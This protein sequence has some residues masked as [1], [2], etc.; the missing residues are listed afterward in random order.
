MTV[1]ILSL[2]ALCFAA[3][4][5]ACQSSAP[6]SPINESHAPPFERVENQINP[7]NSRDFLSQQS[8]QSTEQENRISQG[9]GVYFSRPIDEE[10]NLTEP[11]PD[12]Q[13]GQDFVFNSAPIALIIDEVLSSYKVNYSVSPNVHGN[14]S[15]RLHGVSSA[16]EAVAGLN[17]ALGL[18]SYEITNAPGGYLISSKGDASATDSEIRFLSPD[19]A[20]LDGAETAVLQLRYSKV[21]DVLGIARPLLPGNLLKGSDEARGFVLLQ[22]DATSLRRAIRLLRSLDV[23]WLESVSTGVFPIQNLPAEDLVAEITPIINRMG[24]ISLVPIERLQTVVVFART[25]EALGITETWIERLDIKGRLNAEENVLVY[26]ARHADAQALVELASPSFSRVRSSNDGGNIGQSENQRPSQFNNS[27]NAPSYENIFISVDEGRNSIVAQGESSELIRLQNLLEMLDQPQRQVI[28]EATIAEVQLTGEN[29]FG[30]QWRLIEDRLSAAFSPTSSGAPSSLFPG[31][32]ISYTN[33]G[34]DAVVNALASTS[35]VEIV[36]APRL[37]VLNNEPA[38]LQIGDQVPVI[39]QSAVS[40]TDPGAPVVNSTSYRD[41]GVILTVTPQIR[42]GG[43]IVLEVSQEVSNVAQTTT[44][45]IDSPTITQRS[46]ESKLVV[47][48]GAT[49][50]LGG[51]L[52]TTSSQSRLGLPYL[53]DVPVVGSLFGSNGTS[54]RRTELVVLISPRIVIPTET[55]IE[56]PERIR[57]ALIRTRSP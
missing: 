39:T 9:T 30:I 38:R 11:D 3:V 6:G 41:T 29:Q 21:D 32:S 37:M 16:D 55:S 52:S 14:M 17:A 31:V 54:E 48:D 35:E 51:L 1:R 20:L 43:M 56:I 42:A 22:G 18:Q 33:V 24:G 12:G 53:K 2:S 47:R 26:D 28:I 36:S 10:R 46:I 27:R 49:A 19:D 50:V 5:A 15:L 57:E 40:I 23:N 25:P 8:I 7:V 45:N 13:N 4:L 44:S 34:I